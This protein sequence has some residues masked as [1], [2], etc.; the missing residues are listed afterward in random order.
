MFNTLTTNSIQEVSTIIRFVQV[1]YETSD[2]HEEGKIV[3]SNKP[4]IR[5]EWRV[6]ISNSTITSLY[7][8]YEK[9]TRKILTDYLDFLT[10][11]TKYSDLDETLK[12][13]YRIGISDILRKINSN[14][15]RHLNY[16]TII[17]I[18]HHAINGHSY[19]LAPEAITQHENNLRFD[20]LAH[21]VGK[22]GATNFKEWVARDEWLKGFFIEEEKIPEL[23]K[24]E[25]DKFIAIRN[26]ISHGIS[27]N[28]EGKDQLIEYCFLV[29]SL[30]RCLQE[31]LIHHAVGVKIKQN[32]LFPAGRII[33]RYKGGKIIVVKFTAGSKLKIGDPIYLNGG[34][35][36]VKSKVIGIKRYGLEYNEFFL[37][38]SGHEIGLKI[39]R[40]APKNSKVFLEKN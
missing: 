18:Y 37:G 34:F 27:S 15:Y 20:I 33:D 36:R 7:A 10:S 30:M 39:D 11:C 31:F 23:L 5:T 6:F 24:S 35:S 4:P 9:F 14:Q 38:T 3:F 25:L 29:I 17:E 22:V 16:E 12:E 21:Q 32:L 8:S 2:F 40:P 26:D 28:I 19:R 1:L 13:N